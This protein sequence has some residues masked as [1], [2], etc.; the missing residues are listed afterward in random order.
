MQARLCQAAPPLL[1][2]ECC[3]DQPDL[4]ALDKH[5]R[6]SSAPPPPWSHRPSR[7]R[8]A[9]PLRDR[10]SARLP[11]ERCQAVPAL[12]PH[13]GWQC[14]TSPPAGQWLSS[15]GPLRDFSLGR[16]YARLARRSVP[17][18][19]NARQACMGRCAPAPSGSRRHDQ[20]DP[21]SA[22]GA[23]CWCPRASPWS[24]IETASE[25]QEASTSSVKTCAQIRL[26]GVGGRCQSQARITQ[27]KAWHSSLGWRS[28]RRAPSTSHHKKY[29]ALR[30]EAQRCA[31]RPAAGQ[32]SMQAAASQGKG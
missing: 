3:R 32:G 21:R 23:P 11:I 4:P 28:P 18:R 27:R 26:R 14:P 2:C 16:E 8:P 1:Q 30:Q 17:C 7:A 29:D 10:P 31:H 5:P 9:R 19:R 20:G 24:Q 25:R 12:L 15:I 22:T 6:C 13:V